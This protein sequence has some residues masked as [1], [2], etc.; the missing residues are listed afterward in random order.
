MNKKIDY[1]RQIDIP[2]WL[3]KEVDGNELLAG[4]LLRR[5]I[6]NPEK[7]KRFLE[8]SYYQPAGPEIFPHMEEAAELVL[9]AVKNNR[10]ICIYGDY[11]VDGVTSTVILVN[12]IERIGGEV[13]YHLPDRFKEGYGLNKEVIKSLSSEVELI[14]TCDCGISNYE[15]I[16]LAKKLEL[17]VLVTDHHQLPQELPPA[18]YILSP[19]LLPD[20]HQVY[21]IPGAGMA[22]YLA[23]AVLEKLGREEETVHY[24]DLLSLAIVADVVPLLKENRYLLQ[25]GL[26]ELMK[27]ERNGLIELFRAAGIVDVE[28][29]TEEDI[30]YRI[31]PMINS[32]GRIR[33]ADLAVELLLADDRSGARKYASQIAGLNER[34]KKLQDEVIEEAVEM[35]GDNHEG[36]AAVLYRPHW[37][38]GVIGIAAGRLC[39]DYRVPVLLMCQKEDEKTITGSARSIPEIHIYQEIKKCEKYLD[40]YGGHAGA[41]GFSLPRDNLTGFSKNVAGVLNESLAGL[42]E[43]KRVISIDGEFPLDEVKMQDYYQLRKLAP[44]GEKNPRP[45]FITR[46]TEIVYS[47][48]TS[49]G[50][51]LRLIAAKNG[52]QHPAIWWWAGEQELDNKAALIYSLDVNE[53]RGKKE[54]QLV[55]EDVIRTEAQTGETAKNEPGPD[56]E[57]TDC[58]GWKDHNRELPVFEDAFYYYEG[59]EEIEDKEILSDRKTINPGQ[60]INRYQRTGRET[61]VFLSC[62]PS[63]EI[64]KEIIITNRPAKIVL[65]YAQSDIVKGSVFIKQLSGLIKHIISNKNGHLDLYQ[66]AALTGQV[67]STVAAGIKYLEAKGFI[68]VN[69]VNPRLF[70]VRGNRGEEKRNSRLKLKELKDLISETRSFV[71]Y[72]LRVEVDVLKDI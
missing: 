64:F 28:K 49:G 51:H 38:Q 31:A 18:D 26:P 62:P 25:I 66:L 11:D 30:A 48:T 68:T 71:K 9:T 8:P 16:A 22:Y 53:F 27:T 39:E 42:K 60:V 44:F 32:A 21:N 15:E 29:I 23:A 2:D 36:G 65:A 41:A 7:V 58:R 19:K 56:F 67:E 50:Q 46:D 40:K 52:V 45:K 14:I 63:L 69:R 1:K 4:I 55:V 5:G 20:G 6:D 3:K 37:H 10:K 33:K 57:I 47:R 70:L 61:L 54:I 72:M 59:L 12:L 35:I 13:I 43:E 34:R 17:E 24:L